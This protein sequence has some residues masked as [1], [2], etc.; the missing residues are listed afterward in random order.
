M[1]LIRVVKHSPDR[2]NINPYDKRM[3]DI[4]IST[5]VTR[6]QESAA[7][8]PRPNNAFTLERHHTRRTA[9][10][11]SVNALFSTDTALS[12][13]LNK[14]KK[15]DKR[16]LRCAR[17]NYSR[18][19]RF[20]S[21]RGWTW[22]WRGFSILWLLTLRFQADRVTTGNAQRLRVTMTS[23]RHA[24]ALLLARWNPLNSTS[25]TLRCKGE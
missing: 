11:S 20:S 15:L 5:F 21:G 1:S 23:S 3:D 25:A 12:R 22:T 16:L 13:C 8:P 18:Q 9:C 14:W 17:V 6:V 2:A 19:N 7:V 4:N 10:R 24:P